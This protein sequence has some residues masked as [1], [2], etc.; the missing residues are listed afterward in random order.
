M[1][2]QMPRTP[3]DDTAAFVADSE[4]KAVPAAPEPAP[5]A[6]VAAAAVPAGPAVSRWRGRRVPVLV[7]GAA[8]V[9]GMV[10]GGGVVGAAALI[11]GHHGE[12]RG[13]HISR[14]GRPGARGGD[15]ARDGER[16]PRP[17]GNRERDGRGPGR[18]GQDTPAPVPSAVAPSA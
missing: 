4:P 5:T 3:D 1:S 9:L 16:G 13:G 12:D 6:P 14:E 7:A 15:H 8:L 2:D 17:G 11:G 10:L 18:D